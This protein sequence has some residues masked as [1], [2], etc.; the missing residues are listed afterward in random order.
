VDHAILALKSI[1][2]RVPGA[3]LW[4]AGSGSEKTRL[5][6]LAKS[7][8]IEGSVKFFG[9]VDETKKIELLSKAHLVLFPATR[10]GWGLVVIEANACGTP[11]IGYDV[12]G[13][14]DSIKDGV[15]GRLVP[16]GDTDAMAKAAISLLL[17]E[18]ALEKLSSSS[19]RYAKTFSIDDSAKELLQVLERC[20]R[21]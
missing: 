4:I 3:V 1:K 9:R 17:S 18:P 16:S 12:E 19:V 11:V 8:G 5:E 10:E 20:C 7:L 14:R 13:L 6:A 2:L 15:N 21:G